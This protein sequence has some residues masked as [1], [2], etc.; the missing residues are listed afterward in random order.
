[1][2]IPDIDKTYITVEWTPPESDGNAP[3]QFYMI[4]R[5]QP[6]SKQWDLCG[7]TSAANKVRGTGLDAVYQFK[8]EKV[9][10][11]KEY[12]YRIKAVNKAGPGPFCDHNKPAV[13]CQP[14]PG[15]ENRSYPV[16]YS[17]NNFKL[18]EPIRFFCEHILCAA[19]CETETN[20]QII[21]SL[22]NKIE[23]AKAFGK[24][25]ERVSMRVVYF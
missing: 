1:M 18:R 2:A 16:A 23:L 10:E 7:D 17:L 14:K 21:K 8:D 11:G 12:Y 9:N 24:L 19:I 15:A 3:I 4:E 6:K 13:K 5:R 22:S 20:F 25:V